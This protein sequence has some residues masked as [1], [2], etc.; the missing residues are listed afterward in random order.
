M[1]T[2]LTAAIIATAFTTILTAG[3]AF[4][5][6]M[7]KVGKF[8]DRPLSIIVPAGPGGG[9]D[10]VSRAMANVLP[11]ITGVP[12]QVVNKP[13]GGALTAIVDYMAVPSDGY[14]ILQHADVIATAYVSRKLQVDPTKDLAT[15]AIAQ[16]TFSQLYVR[17]D[18]TRFSDWNSFLAYAKANPKAV[19]VANIAP[20]GSMER[21]NMLLLEQQLGFETTQ[22]SFDKPTERY[23]ALVGGHVDV[24]FE[25]PGDVR[26]FLE[27]KQ[28]KPILTFM[29]DRPS[30][31]ADTPSL[32]DVGATFAPLL[33]FRGFWVHA[34][35]PADR[36]EYLAEAIKRGYE[37]KS[38]SDFNESKY[39][40]LTRSY[41]GPA[42]AAQLLQETIDT[43]AD[44]YKKLG[45]IQ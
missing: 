23:A 6:P 13:G 26:Q 43:Y 40:H 17:A 2:K 38:F 36:K 4:A 24:L 29:K 37:T 39:M 32:T 14:T 35:T 11:E 27:A 41:Y 28:F 18:E 8:P 30:A 42:E 25:Q 7:Q 5:Q 21:V 20:P 19:T 45:M 9:S 34:D 16:V 10:Q 44:V 1:L 33:R 15:L 31:F 12:A 22:I 3:S